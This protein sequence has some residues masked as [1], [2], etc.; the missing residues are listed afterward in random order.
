MLG[1]NT[2]K[3][4]FKNNWRTIVPLFGFIAFLACPL[5]A[6]AADD[7]TLGFI[8]DNLKSTNLHALSII[9]GSSIVAGIMFLMGSVFKFHRWKQNPQQVSVGQG[10]SLLLI[11]VIMV[12]LPL[13]MGTSKRALL[14]TN[15]QVNKLGDSRL[16]NIVVPQ[17]E[18]I[19]SGD[20]SSAGED[21]L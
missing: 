3:V 2:F 19:D 10:I 8:R 14:G 13:S 7:L 12:S 11:G 17:S 20:D 1:F 15:S 18:R 6:Y 5:S 21:T 9:D 4:L 16:E